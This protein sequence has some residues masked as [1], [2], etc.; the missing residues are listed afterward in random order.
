MTKNCLDSL[1]VKRI[2]GKNK[3]AGS[4]PAPGSHHSTTP[5]PH[6]RGANW[7]TG[8]PHN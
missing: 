8:A 7:P 2:L 3:S 6:L 5:P 1:V 4:I